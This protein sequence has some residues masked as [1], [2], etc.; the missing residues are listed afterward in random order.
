MRWK[1]WCAWFSFQSCIPGFKGHPLLLRLRIGS[2]VSWRFSYEGFFYESDGLIALLST[3]IRSWTFTLNRVPFLLCSQLSWLYFC[4]KNWNATSQQSLNEALLR[5]TS[6][7]VLLKS[8]HSSHITPLVT[9]SPG[10][11]H[12]VSWGTFQRQ[13]LL[14]VLRNFPQNKLFSSCCL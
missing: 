10:I 9:S 13:R 14:A 5:D 2:Q 8:W 11:H 12:P 3:Y 7:T 6:D 1:H 4:I